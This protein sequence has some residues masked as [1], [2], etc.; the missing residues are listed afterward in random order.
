MLVSKLCYNS[1][2]QLQ[3]RLPFPLCLSRDRDRWATGGITGLKT[4]RERAIGII[5]I[6]GSMSKYSLQLKKKKKIQHSTTVRFWHSFNRCPY[7]QMYFQGN[8][9]KLYCTQLKKS[10]VSYFAT[11]PGTLHVKHS[12]NAC[13]KNIK[14]PQRILK[15]AVNYQS[16]DN[17]FTSQQ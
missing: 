4:E 5:I 2:F 8:S 15:S 16:S 11:N 12:V 14:Q 17:H 13:K 3:V 10:Q 1:D 7:L 6:F 9:A